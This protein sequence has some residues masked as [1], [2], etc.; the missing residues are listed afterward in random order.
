MIGKAIAGRENTLCCAG[1]ARESGDEGEGTRRVDSER[2][3][4]RRQSSI[5]RPQCFRQTHVLIGEHAAQE[6]TLR[7]PLDPSVAANPPEV[8]MRR[9]LHERQRRREGPRREGAVRGARRAVQGVARPPVGER[10]P[11]LGKPRLLRRHGGT[12]GTGR[13]RFQGAVLALM[14]PILLGRPFLEALRPDPQTNP[15]G[16]QR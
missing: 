1:G 2:S 16:A 8:E 6:Q 4:A 9:I 3:A 5:R 10:L 7:T 13:L 14:S 15:P 11:P 12:W